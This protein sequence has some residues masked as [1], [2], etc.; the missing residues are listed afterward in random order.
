[1]A[2]AMFINCLA[3]PIGIAVAYV[4]FS[5]YPHTDA[6]RF[7]FAFGAI[8]AV[9]G[10]IMRSKLPESFIWK[11]TQRIK[12]KHQSIQGGYRVLFNKHYLKATIALCLSWLLMDISYYSIGLFTPDLL[13][14]LHLGTTGNFVT[15]TKTIVEST[16]FVSSFV[17]LGA[18]LSIFAIDKVS[19]IH[20]QKMGF[21]G[22]FVG[23]LIL[24]LSSQLSLIPPYPLIF[25]GFLTYNV[26]VN[27]GPGTTTYLLPVEI[28]PTHVRATGHG[29]ASGAAKF[30]AFL[31]AIFLPE[32]QQAYGVHITMLVLSFSLLLGFALTNLLNGYKMMP[33]STTE[34]SLENESLDSQQQ[35]PAFELET[36]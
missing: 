14:A 16:V 5:V 6:W 31:G 11:A 12:Q 34:E 19:R 21:I 1:M 23:L 13:S 33:G 26:F 20:L 15:D 4:I 35:S 17:A 18:L 25:A 30:G 22:A 24:A 8:P 32:F 9:I 7:M 29:L 10:L 36:K 28:Y 27:M 2:S 3:S